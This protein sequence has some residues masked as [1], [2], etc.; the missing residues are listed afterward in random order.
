MLDG[1][2]VAP[3]LRLLNVASRD[4]AMLNPVLF[5]DLADLKLRLDVSEIGNIS[6]KFSA[7]GCDGVTKVFER[8]VIQIDY[9]DVG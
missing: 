9:C 3:F 7:M 4:G 5:D 2:T 1:S 8:V 6:D